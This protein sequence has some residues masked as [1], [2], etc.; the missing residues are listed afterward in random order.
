MAEPD[1][2][3]PL[4]FATLPE[5]AAAA[6]EL[7]L[8]VTWEVRPAIGPGWIGGGRIVRFHL[9][10]RELDEGSPAHAALAEIVVRALAIPAETDEVYVQGEGELQL[11]R[12]VLTWEVWEAIPYGEG[13]SRHGVTQLHELEVR[14]LSS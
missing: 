10:E 8:T 7:P 13:R 6:A 2:G 1:R 12:C 11:G 5:L 9:G 3:G 14:L 4:S